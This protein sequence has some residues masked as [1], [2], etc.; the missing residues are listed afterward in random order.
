MANY[1]IAVDIGG[2]FTDVVIQNT[3]DGTLW[4]AK[5]P[6]TPHDLALGFMSGVLNAIQQAGRRPFERA[7]HLPRHNHRH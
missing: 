2:T 1:H 5:T 3:D 7:P 6:S 4:T